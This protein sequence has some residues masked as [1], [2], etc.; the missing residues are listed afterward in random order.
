V[1]T[2]VPI[3]FLSVGSANTDGALGFLDT[4]DFLSALD[5]PPTVITT[6]YDLEEDSLSSALLVKMC[7]AYG[8]LGARGVSI[9]FSSG[10][11]GVAGTG[12]QTC[13]GKPFVPTFPPTCP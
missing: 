10:D 12:Q 6:S 13:T 8:A 4:I 2:D 1:A 7:N 3:T 11:H 5:T 9:L